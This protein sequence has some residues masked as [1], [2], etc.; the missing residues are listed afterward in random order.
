MIRSLLLASAACALSAIGPGEAQAQAR[1]QMAT[2]YP[3]GNFH[4]RNIRSFLEA[5]QAAG[6]E[7]IDE[8]VGGAALCVQ[9]PPK[10]PGGLGRRRRGERHD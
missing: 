6:L 9:A 8:G 2:A 10:R 5:A 7:R 3:D 4:T 1:W